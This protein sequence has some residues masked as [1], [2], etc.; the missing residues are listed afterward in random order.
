MEYL[1]RFLEKYWK[2]K[3]FEELKECFGIN[4]LFL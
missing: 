2:V 1:K 3:E 4:S